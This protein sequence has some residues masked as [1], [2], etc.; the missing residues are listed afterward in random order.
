MLHLVRSGPRG[1]HKNVWIAS[2]SSVRCLLQPTVLLRTIM[3]SALSPTRS[4]ALVAVEQAMNQIAPLGLADTSFDNVGTLLESPTPGRGK[5]V[6]L[7]IDLTT[8]VAEEILRDTSVSVAVIYHPVIFKPLK[9]LS[10][11]PS[12]PG[13]KAP[14]LSIVHNL[15]RLSGAG[16]S[17][18]CPHTS[19]DAAP[20]G[21]TA[22]LLNAA[23]AFRPV[24]PRAI[25]P[26]TDGALGGEPIGHGRLAT[27]QETNT[28]DK[29]IASLKQHTTLSH[30]QVARGQREFD[31]PVSSVAVC[32]GSGA[33]MLAQ[34]EADVYVTGEMSHHEI[35]AANA[36]GTSVVLLN[37]SNSE[38]RYLHLC[39][40]S[41]LQQVLGTEYQ[42]VTSEL[43]AD[44][45]V[46]R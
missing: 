40:A 4:T 19:L 45:L 15:L 26:L 16:V 14:N 37:H 30:V 32:C 18:Y 29:I 9:A 43:D 6:V 31:H 33:S 42:V 39:L 12:A 44:P 38:R 2:A 10:F 41:Q 13:P 20:G 36:N 8:A 35:L 23:T 1:I 3:S 11:S 5:K 22:W 21:M 46:V 17:V 7:A 24:K 27:V 34:T 25:V 28:L